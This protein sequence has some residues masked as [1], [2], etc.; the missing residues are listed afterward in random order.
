MAIIAA[1]HFKIIVTVDLVSFNAFNNTPLL[2]TQCNSK[3]FK[4]ENNCWFYGDHLQN[5]LALA[6]KKLEGPGMV[7]WCEPFPSPMDP[8]LLRGEENG[9]WVILII[10]YGQ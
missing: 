1:K 6:Q 8:P 9:S 4:T 3:I 10:N 7:R 5:F 2:A